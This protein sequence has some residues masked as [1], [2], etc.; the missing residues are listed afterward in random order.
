M[1][2]PRPCALPVAVLTGWLLV[3]FFLAA[4]AGAAIPSAQESPQRTETQLQARDSLNR[5]VQ[6]FKN[7]QYDEAIVEFRRAKELDPQLLNARLYLATAY[8]SQYI[9]REPS[10]ENRH[11]GEC[12][13]AEYRG[14]LTLQPENLSGV[15]GIGSVLFQMA[16]EPFDLGKF[17]ESKSYQ[18]KHMRIRPDDPEPYYWVGVIDWTLSF[19]ANGELR[20]RFNKEHARGEGLRDTD[21]LPADLRVQYAREYGAVIGEG[22]ECLKHAIELKPDYDD[23]KAYLSLMYRRKVDT[24]ETQ[25]EREHLEKMANDLIDEVK[26]IKQERKQ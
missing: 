13:I 11:W 1:L 24:V 7:G 20:E 2:K 4:R 3:W 26:A 9:P 23:A 8:A 18:L 22:I 15:D 10:E 6:A 19:R 14:L 16:G 5:G 21:P 12:A 25:A 17:E